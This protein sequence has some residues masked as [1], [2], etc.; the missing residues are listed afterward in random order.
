[1]KMTKTLLA[2][3][4][5]M[6]VTSGLAQSAAVTNLDTVKSKDSYQQDVRRKKR[7][8]NGSGCDDAGDVAEHP[9]CRT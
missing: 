6:F 8:P 9:E 2:A 7:I 5:L 1:M 4:A 3:M